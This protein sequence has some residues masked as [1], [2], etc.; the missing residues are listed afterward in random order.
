ME[1]GFLTGLKT[2]LGH[3]YFYTVMR[4]INTANQYSH[5][6]WTAAAYAAE[7]FIDTEKEV[8]G[9][10]IFSN[11]AIE[12]DH[13]QTALYT[14]GGE[15]WRTKNHNGQ[16]GRWWEAS[17]NHE[18]PVTFCYVYSDGYNNGMA[19]FDDPTVAHGVVPAFCIQ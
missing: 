5:E 16:P 10:N 8:F 18:D 17:P 7:I 13:R 12:A 3:D 14:V 9:E 2:A 15:S 1:G 6:G 11:P 19:N 4:N